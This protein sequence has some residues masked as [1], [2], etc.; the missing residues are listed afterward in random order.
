MT[1]YA[2]NPPELKDARSIGYNHAIIDGQQFYMAGQV[3]MDADS[4]VVGDDIETQARKAYE[5]VGVLLEAIGMT[6]ADVA[7]VTTHIVDAKEHYYDG[8]KEV[9]LETFEEPYP[10]HTVLG[11]DQLANEDYLVEVEVEL[12]LTEA[13]V[14]AIEPDGDVIREL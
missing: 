13:D 5:N 3:S 11:H 7:K 10:C 9:Y 14:D 4:N 1:R 12:P 8:Y 2:I 6:Y